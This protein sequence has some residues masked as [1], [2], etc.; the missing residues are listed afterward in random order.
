MAAAGF[1]TVASFTEVVFGEDVVGAFAVEIHAFNEGFGGHGFYLNMFS[2][3]D[4]EEE[5][6]SP[7]V[8]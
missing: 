6:D 5:R 2:H 8:Y 3:G 4:T 1:A 7:V